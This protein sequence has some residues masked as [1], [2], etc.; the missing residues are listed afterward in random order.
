MWILVNHKQLRLATSSTFAGWSGKKCLHLNQSLNRSGAGFYWLYL[1]PNAWLPIGLVQ[2]N[3]SVSELDESYQRLNISFYFSELYSTLL[4][5]GYH[6]LRG[7][8]IRIFCKYVRRLCYQWILLLKCACKN[9]WIAC[10]RIVFLHT[11]QDGFICWI[12]LSMRGTVK[13]TLILSVELFKSLHIF[14]QFWNGR[15]CFKMKI[16][17]KYL[18]NCIND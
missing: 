9:L 13:A 6:W 7:F 1:L 14:G 2:S 16:T 10:L 18:L 15:D 17:D 5:S 3:F 8:L 12:C 11:D 4:D